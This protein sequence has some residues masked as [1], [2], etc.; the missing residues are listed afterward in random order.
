[1]VKRALPWK[2]WNK[3]GATEW[4]AERLKKAKS[5]G[6]IQSDAQ[7]VLFDGSGRKKLALSVSHSGTH[8]RDLTVKMDG[9]SVYWHR[10]VAF[11]YSPAP[12][13]FESLGGVRHRFKDVFGEK[14]TWDAFVRSKLQAD[15]GPR[16]TRFILIDDLRLC[17]AERNRELEKERTAAKED[18]K[19]SIDSMPERMKDVIDANGGPT[20]W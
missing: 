1:M 2:V 18:I 14:F 20:G 19:S 10:C 3:A 8:R 5:W 12:H 9:K 16:G 4:R 11:A 15:H 6:G 7:P 13:Y 17:T